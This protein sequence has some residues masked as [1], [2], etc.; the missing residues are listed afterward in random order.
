MTA[1]STFYH[2]R[3]GSSTLTSLEDCFDWTQTYE[4]A[5]SSIAPTLLNMY[6]PPLTKPKMHIM[7]RLATERDEVSLVSQCISMAQRSDSTVSLQEVQQM[8]LKRSTQNA[9]IKCLPY[10]LEQG[11]DVS[12]L[13][14][15]S[16]WG[17]N[18]TLVSI[19]TVLE[20]LVAH[21]YDINSESGR[22][23][24]L[25]VVG[26][27]DYELVK[28]CLDQGADLNPPDP[29]PPTSRPREPILERAAMAGNIDTFELL[30]SRGAPLNRD[31]GIFPKAVMMATEYVSDEVPYN[32][33]FMQ[34]LDMLRHLIQVIGCDV[35]SHSYGAYY[36]SGSACSTP[37]CWVACHSRGASARELT[38]FLLDHGGDPDLTLQYTGQDNQ[39]VVVHSAR[40]AARSG[41]WRGIPNQKFLDVLEEWEARRTSGEAKEA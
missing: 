15:R 23:P 10:V 25:W 35:N 21:G 38:W 24:V 27:N 29:A 11:A 16:V 3:L 40:N 4:S 31:L 33:R 39:L 19:R 14:P 18:S 7:L 17:E 28:W 34:Q 1:N 12:K 41:S 2:P 5:T 20:I 22:H 37:L 30:R 36:G 32:A 9:A 26:V 8:A 13:S 6:E